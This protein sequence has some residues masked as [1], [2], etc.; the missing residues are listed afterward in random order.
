MT[1]K[2][3]L[4]GEFEFPGIGGSEYLFNDEQFVSAYPFA[5]EPPG[6]FIEFLE[7]IALDIL[8]VAA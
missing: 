3:I 6:R 1:N 5:N 2:L 8:A 4:F 7:N